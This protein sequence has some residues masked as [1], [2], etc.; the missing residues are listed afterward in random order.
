ML[1]CMCRLGNW[2][3]D[4]FTEFPP[5]NAAFKCK[6]LRHLVAVPHDAAFDGTGI[7]VW[8]HDSSYGVGED[9][10]LE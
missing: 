6:T 4:Y 2:G 10:S 8:L 1:T 3:G 7:L 9:K 5:W